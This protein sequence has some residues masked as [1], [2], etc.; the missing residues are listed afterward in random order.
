MLTN[1]QMKDDGRGIQSYEFLVSLWVPSPPSI[2]LC[3]TSISLRILR[4]ESFIIRWELS[5][6]GTF[7][8]ESPNMVTWSLN[9]EKCKSD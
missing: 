4:D 6:S 3:I 1:K 5:G 8:F 7:S 2:P 9:P